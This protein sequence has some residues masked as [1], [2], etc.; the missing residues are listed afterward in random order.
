M[1]TQKRHV[2]PVDNTRDLLWK[3]LESL[4]NEIRSV[5]DKGHLS[6]LSSDEFGTLALAA[7]SV[8]SLAEDLR[9]PGRDSDHLTVTVETDEAAIASRHLIEESKRP[10]FNTSETIRTGRAFFQIGDDIE[11]HVPFAWRVR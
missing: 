8:A 3:A 7:R 1:T 10:A 9:F 6:L 2:R 4:R 5:D 11:R